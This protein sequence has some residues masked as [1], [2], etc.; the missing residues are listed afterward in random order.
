MADQQNWASPVFLVLSLGSLLD[1]LKSDEG[2]KMQLPKLID[3]S[4]QV[5][6]SFAASTHNLLSPALEK[7][8]FYG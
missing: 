6:L 7:Y 3:F 8:C 1:F 5:I 4:A 2:F